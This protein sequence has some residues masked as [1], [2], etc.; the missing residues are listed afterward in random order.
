[1]QPVSRRRTKTEPRTHRN[2]QDDGRHHRAQGE[3]AVLP[4]EQEK[5][6]DQADDVRFESERNGETDDA[7][8]FGALRQ[9]TPHGNRAKAAGQLLGLAKHHRLGAAKQ[10][11]SNA[12]GAGQ[13]SHAQA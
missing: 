13:R 7:N 6:P 5:Q 11:Q 1:M 8:P 4:A 2:R 10:H 3:R 12:D 9:K